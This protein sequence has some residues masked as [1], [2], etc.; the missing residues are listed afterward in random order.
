MAAASAHSNFYCQNEW[1]WTFALTLP[2]PPG[3]GGD[4][5]EEVSM[6]SPHCLDSPDPAQAT[7]PWGVD[8][9]GPQACDP[10]PPGLA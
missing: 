3:E 8:T 7:L 10:H 6:G 9:P 5:A 4:P 1:R 2:P